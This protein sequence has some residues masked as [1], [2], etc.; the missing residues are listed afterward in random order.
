MGSSHE[1]G[2]SELRGLKLCAKMCVHDTI[3][4]QFDS[5][6]E[7]CNQVFRIPTINMVMHITC[8]IN[9]MAMGSSFGL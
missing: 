9:C 3:V 5:A 7:T 6:P 8:Q 4:Y 2:Q 1:A